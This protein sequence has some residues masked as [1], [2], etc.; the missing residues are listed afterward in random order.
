MRRE[1][2]FLHRRFILA[3]RLSAEFGYVS[4]PEP[5]VKAAV[6]FLPSFWDST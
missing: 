5:R 6:Q 3:G 4:E 1:D 2:R